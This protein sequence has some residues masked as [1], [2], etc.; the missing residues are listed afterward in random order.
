LGTKREN[1]PLSG[2]LAE[3]N[4]LLSAL[5]W[6][7]RAFAKRYFEE[8][9]PSGTEEECA[10]FAET[11]NRAFSR[12][13]MSDEKIEAYLSFIFC[14]DEYRRLDLVRPENFSAGQ[15]DAEFEKEMRAISKQISKQI[16]DDDSRDT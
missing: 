4:G 12:R 1:K 3:L 11:F 16:K 8:I 6:S 5:T 10:T 14:Q 13:S 9:N 7:H 2:K 15:F